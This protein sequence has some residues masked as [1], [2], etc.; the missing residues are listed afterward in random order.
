MEGPDPERL[1]A[2]DFDEA[3][4]DTYMEGAGPERLLAADFDEA[5]LDMGEDFYGRPP[6][7]DGMFAG[8][9]E[10]DINPF[11]RQD[12]VIGGDPG[13][14]AL[15]AAEGEFSQVPPGGEGMYSGD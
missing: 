2:G 15:F 12:F 8:G 5:P 9:E 6:E 14:A 7:S 1:L 10:C 4:L 13:F 11:A 3:P